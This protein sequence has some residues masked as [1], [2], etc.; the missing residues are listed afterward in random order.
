M[1]TGPSERGDK[2]V[3]RWGPGRFA[4]LFVVLLV[5][6][7]LIVPVFISII[8]SFSEY[9]GLRIFEKGLTL[10]WYGYVW[11]NYSHTIKY[12]VTIAAATVAIDI[13]LGV[14]A[15]YALSKARSRWAGALEEVISIPVAIPGIAIALAL[16]QSHRY[17]SGSWL[18]IVVGHVVFTMPLMLRAVTAALRTAKLATMEEAAASLGAGRRTR[19]LRVV[20][21]NVRDAIVAGALMV[22]T[23]SL[24]EFNLT[25]F[26]YT[27]LTMTM[28]VGLYESYASLRLE[29]GS[30]YT[31][32]FLL[33]TI[34][35]M[36]L[37]QYLGSE[38]IEGRGF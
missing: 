28:P 8:G 19:L 22:L 12:S 16:I 25:F 1:P 26:L 6:A 7:F 15:A 37:I 5:S 21:P 29:I 2:P 31:A 34:P 24:G 4:V 38:K 30:A 35:L 23:M 36:T 10:K 17:L 20:V 13:L 27:P 33:L 14:A 3:P 32:L 9:W 18:F 11:Q